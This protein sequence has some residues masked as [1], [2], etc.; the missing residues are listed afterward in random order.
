[1]LG[2]SRWCYFRNGDESEIKIVRNQLSDRR[3]TT[4]VLSPERCPKGIQNTRILIAT[5]R[6]RTKLICLWQFRL[7]TGQ[8]F[9]EKF[10]ILARLFRVIFKKFA[11][12]IELKSLKFRK[13]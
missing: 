13:M 12:F 11:L 2:F 3:G 9:H 5:N 1:M 4:F 8:E 7:F 6:H 10:R